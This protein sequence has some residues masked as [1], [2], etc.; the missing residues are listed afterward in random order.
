MKIQSIILSIALFSSAL[1]VHAEPA[2]SIGSLLTYSNRPLGS[3]E[4]PLLLRT[5]MPDPGLNDEVLTNHHR[6]AKSS[7]YS[8]KQG[9]DRPGD[10]QP[11]DGLP[12]A[13]GVNYGSALSYCWDTVECRLLYAW[14]GG[15]LDMTSYWGD[16]KRGNRQSYGYVPHLVGTMFYQASSK[17]PLKLNGKSISD[18]QNPLKFLGYKKIGPRFIFM[19]ETD[20][21]KVLCEVKVGS[22]S[23][24][25]SVHYSLEGKGTLGYQDNLPGHV[26][27]KVSGNKLSVTIQGSKIAEYKGAPN[28]NLLKGGVNASSG[29][30]VFAAMA[31]A[32]CHS[33]DGSKGHGPSL[34]GIHG[35]KRK[36]NDSDKPV[37]VD[38]AYILESIINPNAKVADGY[39]E[40]YMPP[41]QLKKDEYQS[42]LIY[43]KTLKK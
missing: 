16:P 36:I 3:P 14:E 31:C 20:G 30:R 33:L 25:L 37:L 23:Q 35:K 28:K 24:S 1:A 6:G 27:K 22:T 29:E 2:T 12:A 32:T 7:K 26:I 11:I 21:S 13:I 34:L 19:L 40:N 43:I 4:Q 17:H 8:P 10:Y 39:P 15:F 38:D 18:S 5:F 41:Y 42:L 9:K